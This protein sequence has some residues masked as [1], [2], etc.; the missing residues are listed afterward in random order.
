MDLQSQDLPERLLWGR[1][2]PAGPTEGMRCTCAEGGHH[3]G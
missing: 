3:P 1:S 2:G